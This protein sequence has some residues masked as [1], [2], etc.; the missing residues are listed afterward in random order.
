MEA[1]NAGLSLPTIAENRDRGS[2]RNKYG[3]TPY[4]PL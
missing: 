3:L 4:P 1:D 2:L